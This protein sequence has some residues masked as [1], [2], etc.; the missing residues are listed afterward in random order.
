MTFYPSI[1]FFPIETLNYFPLIFYHILAFVV[2]GMTIKCKCYQ[3][4][5]IH[6]LEFHNVNAWNV[7]SSR[8]EKS[9]DY[10]ILME[11][12]FICLISQDYS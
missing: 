6:L 7:C 10:C 11:T 8:S 3:K 2:I 4:N 1:A 12:F 9:V 5:I